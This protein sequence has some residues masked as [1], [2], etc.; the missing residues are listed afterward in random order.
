MIPH[1]E[2]TSILSHFKREGHKLLAG[3]GHV[4]QNGPGRPEF[5]LD[6]KAQAQA[7]KSL[8]TGS[9]IPRSN[10][11]DSVPF[12]SAIKSKPIDQIRSLLSNVKFKLG[13]QK[14]KEE[15]EGS[16]SVTSEKS[17]TEKERDELDDQ[18]GQFWQASS[19]YRSEAQ[20]KAAGEY[21]IT[22]DGTS[23]SENEPRASAIEKL[24]EA[25]PDAKEGLTPE[26]WK[27]ISEE[28]TADEMTVMLNAIRSKEP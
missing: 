6:L 2:S 22:G 27:A 19:R 14:A 17:M 24:P 16:Q 20:S 9:D 4:T 3:L 13:L 25:D 11:P 5:V 15:K 1:P 21:A 18:L 7:D 10:N 23:T 28:L 8:N 12:D 26:V